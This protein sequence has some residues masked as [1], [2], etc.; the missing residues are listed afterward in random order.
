MDFQ[1]A[2]RPHLFSLS[3][4]P[5]RA[6]PFKSS[7]ENRIESSRAVSCRIQ[8]D[9]G[10]RG[11]RESG[12]IGD[13]KANFHEPGRKSAQADAQPG[14]KSYKAYLTTDPLIFNFRDGA[15][16]ERERERERGRAG[17][18]ELAC[19]RRAAVSTEIQLGKLFTRTGA[20]RYRSTVS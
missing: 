11:T 2:A 17:F 3:R 5:R 8:V 7:F 18:G 20:R 4:H 15:R 13:V 6:R 9:D 10:R 19:S 1:R 12:R 16:R 14:R